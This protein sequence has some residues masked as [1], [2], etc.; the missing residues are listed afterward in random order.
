[1]VIANAS[2]TGNWRLR[3]V[4]GKSMSVGA[5]S[6]RGMKSSSPVA[7]PVST[8]AMIKFGFSS[9]T[10]SLVP[11][12]SPCEG[13]SFPAMGMKASHIIF[14]SPVQCAQ[15]PCEVRF[16]VSESSIITQPTS[17]E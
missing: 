3:K 11:L 2:F 17:T 1:M 13:K 7:E 8:L 10:I 5:M 12:H 15:Q 14:L 6:I 16:K 4:N 9:V